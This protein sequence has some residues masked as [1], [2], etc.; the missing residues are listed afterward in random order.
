M[1][2]DTYRS[3][4]NRCPGWDY[5][6]PGAYFVTICTQG[7]RCYFGTVVDGMMNLNQIGEVVKEEIEKTPQLRKMVKI[8][9]WVI[10]P[11]HVHLIIFITAEDTVET[12]RR[13]VSTDD[14]LVWKPGCLGAIVNHLKGACTRRIRANFNPAFAWQPRYYD[15]IIRD[16]RDLERIHDYISINPVNWR[17]DNLYTFDEATAYA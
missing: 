17:E 5:A 1:F 6:T 16:A 14:V 12:P 8:D 2:R 15:H 7:H 10:M 4:S 9:S 13:D 11:N 3:Q